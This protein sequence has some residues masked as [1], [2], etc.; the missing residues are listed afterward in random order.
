M[1][2]YED[3]VN[4][5]PKGSF[6][7]NQG[8]VLPFR[9]APQEFYFV[10][11][12][13][14]DFGVFVD[15]QFRGTVTSDA[16]GQFIVSVEL[17][18]GEHVIAAENDQTAQR[19]FVYATVRDYAVWYASYADA[20][21]GTSS[22]YGIDPAVAA[23]QAAPKLSAAEALHLDPVHGRALR[24]PNNLNYALDSYR[25]LLQWLRQAYRRYPARD[26]GLEQVVGAFTNSLG[27]ML[28]ATVRPRWVLERNYAPNGRLDD[29]TNYVGSTLPTLNQSSLTF[30]GTV[31]ATS[32]VGAVSAAPPQ[33]QRL[34]VS[35]PS[36]WDGGNL[37]VTGT[38]A[39]GAA[40]S[41]LFTNTGAVVS[42]FR[43]RQGAEIFATVTGISNSVVGTTGTAR[44]GLSE[45]AF[46]RVVDV[47]GAP[48]VE[49]SAAVVDNLVLTEVA[50]VRSLSFTDL[51]TTASPNSTVVEASGRYTIP[52]RIRGGRIVGPAF[53]N[54][55]VSGGRSRLYIS[56]NDLERVT[57]VIGTTS[58]TPASN[59]PL[60]V[61]ADINAAV[62]GS[63]AYVVNP[64]SVRT[65]PLGSAIEID[66]V[67]VVDAN[68]R[69]RLHLDCADASREVF[70]IPYYV[71]DDA[72]AGAP[73]GSTSLSYTSG[74]TI[75]LLQAPFEARVGR[76]VAA[77][78]TGASVAAISGPF[79]TVT[80]PAA[81][82]L[83]VGECI[84]ITGG[85]V[86][87]V[88]GLHRIYEV[89][90]TTQYR[91]RHEDTTTTFVSDAGLDY[92]A[93][94][95]GDVVEVTANDNSTGT[96]TLST[97]IPRNLP[98]GYQVELNGEM[99]YQTRDNALRAEAE[100]VVDVDLDFAPPSA[101]SQ[102]DSL[103]LSTQV[104]PEGWYLAS[105]T[106]AL[107][108]PWGRT[109]RTSLSIERG[110][111]DIELRV[112]V[113][114]V[115]DELRNWPID[116]SFWVT[117]HQSS[118]QAFRVDVSFD[119]GASWVAGTPAS[120]AG[121]FEA[122]GANR[123]SEPRFD[124]VTERVT[125]PF[126]A[127]GLLVRL[128]HV[129]GSSG[130]RVTVERCT[131]TSA[132]EAGW[133]TEAGTI[134]RDGQS[135]LFGRVLYAWS[136]DDLTP[137]ENRALGIEENPNSQ[138]DLVRAA[139]ATLARFDVSEYDVSDNP[140]NVVGAYDDVGWS[141]ATLT[142][143]SLEVG[144]PG[145]FTYARPSR[146]SRERAEV[147]DPNTFGVAALDFPTSH[148]GPYPQNPN[149]SVLLRRDGI[150]VP[151]TAPVGG[152]VPYVFTAR[153]TL[154]LSSV[155][156]SA[157]STY[158]ADYDVLIMA[159]TDT[160]DL[161][162]NFADYIWLVDA[163]IWQRT[164]QTTATR[165]IKASL[166]FDG[167]GRAVLE[168]P[169]DEDKTS[170]SITRDDGINQR[171]VP[172]ADFD[173]VDRNTVSISTALLDNTA[174][175]SIE[176]NGV[177]ASYDRAPVYTLQVR[178]AA[179]VAGLL[180]ATWT[181]T[182][183]N[184]AV[185]DRYHQLRVFFSDVENVEDVRVHGLGIRGLNAFSSSPN[186]PGIILP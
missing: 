21:E 100:V 156:Y 113:P 32:A 40:I 180:G 167:N 183:V 123:I 36:A 75:G 159:E 72:A 175:Y 96:L 174:L 127:E 74:E 111:T 10:D 108:K 122:A 60:Q 52:F 144:V 177:Y 4:A 158:V 29:R 130:D 47:F 80:L 46:I 125:I 131:V 121:R 3:F 43:T 23:V 66:S 44:V 138:I 178:S 99:P 25:T 171:E 114:R 147:L 76:G 112:D 94:S 161:G 101:A 172:F 7:A 35:F 163:C 83:R 5:V 62:F 182:D 155:E 133:A 50:G 162:P 104:V 17:D 37:T 63:S 105:G 169:S 173:Y 65:G 31:A 115:V 179:S 150:P 165:R 126:D 103:E 142:N 38:N 57:A 119:G 139:H 59:T 184:A 117:H 8:Y 93:W 102:F 11:T 81:V 51:T 33:P 87:A 16:L 98:T 13:N 55:D 143:M 28:P 185:T 124:F 15:D 89:V 110:A 67:N 30:V 20:L 118:S 70:G 34:V 24:R 58:T 86:G 69:I 71:G 22:F 95:L 141:N 53:T 148:L 149:G 128:V 27:Y 12:P 129:S 160:I 84:E 85:G 64:A 152:S 19:L 166:D 91:V 92:R 136:P 68:P 78:G 134:I 18:P 107:T 56:I 135:R 48:T 164:Q 41:E 77:S 151:E 146:V 1:P 109:T 61:A 54:L 170:T 132:L 6:Y 14:T 79:A 97:G 90:S 73:A 88:E 181:D 49:G 157:A 137:E 2:R 120:F 145:R 9:D 116:V 153:D 168:P 186:L 45:S 154:D 26:A 106:A 140:V 82:V 39:S 42:G 176:Y